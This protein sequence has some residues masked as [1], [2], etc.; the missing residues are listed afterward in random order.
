M[1][2][3]YFFF[4]LSYRVPKSSQIITEVSCTPTVEHSSGKSHRQMCVVNLCAKSTVGTLFENE[5][6]LSHLHFCASE[7]SYSA[8]IL[9]TRF[10][11]NILQMRHFWC[12]FQTLCLEWKWILCFCPNMDSKLHWVQ[13]LKKSW[14]NALQNSCLIFSCF[15]SFFSMSV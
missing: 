15:E 4:F 6:K 10:A 8:I 9:K 1:T 14:V 7:A 5:A 12:D 13:N 2:L 11:R 3:Q